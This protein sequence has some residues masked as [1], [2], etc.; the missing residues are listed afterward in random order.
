MCNSPFGKLPPP[1]AAT[2]VPAA[3]K[4]ADMWQVGPTYSFDT[5]VPL[6]SE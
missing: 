4:S 6:H 3:E 2:E 5:M 1:H